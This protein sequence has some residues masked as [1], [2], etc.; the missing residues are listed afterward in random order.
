MPSGEFE[1]LFIGLS[2][3][4]LSTSLIF[5]F[6]LVIYLRRSFSEYDS[7]PSLQYPRFFNWIWYC[8]LPRLED[9]FEIE[10]D[11]WQRSD[12]EPLPP[13]SDARGICHCSLTWNY[14]MNIL[15]RLHITCNCLRVANYYI[16]ILDP[17][18]VEL[19]NNRWLWIAV[20]PNNFFQNRVYYLF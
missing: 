5:L 16:M 18:I 20:L 15:E 13:L 9:E 7:F 11:L 17:E 2:F 12:I 8:F 10:F 1:L 14:K 6:I 19:K 4:I 3:V